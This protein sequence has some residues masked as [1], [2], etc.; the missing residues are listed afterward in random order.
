MEYCEAVCVKKYAVL[1]MGLFLMGMSGASLSQAAENEPAVSSTPAEATGKHAA[2]AGAETAQA[3]PDKPAPDKAVPETFTV[4]FET[5]R[6]DVLIDVTRSWAPAGAD[7]FYELVKNGY[8][9]DI[10]F[11]RVIRGF[12][13]QVGISGDPKQNAL[14]RA[15]RIKDDPVRQ[16]NTRGM[17]SFATAGPN[18]RTTQIFINFG[19]NSGLDKMGFSPF[20]KVRDMAVVDTLYADYG[21]GAPQGVGP[22]QGRIQAEGNAYLKQDFPKLDYIKKA[23]ILDKK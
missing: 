12:M 9:T 18:T 19:D 22:E 13:A 10:A 21:E 5:T 16:S 23:E 20:G 4:K 8:Y 2:K 14:W 7:R 11:F 1:G 3:G 15:R 6:G 17:V